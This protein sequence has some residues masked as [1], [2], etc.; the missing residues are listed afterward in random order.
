MRAVDD[1]QHLG[2]LL[3]PRG[4]APVVLAGA[5]DVVAGGRAALGPALDLTRLPQ[6]DADLRHHEADR[7]VGAHD[8]RDQRIVPAVL[9]G[10]HVALG[11]EVPGRELGGPRG[12]VR[13]HRDHREVEVL[14]QP[15][16][17]VEVHRL[18]ARRERVV[19]PRHRD[20][21]RVDGVDLLGPRVDE[22]QVVAGPR[23][24][25]ADVA[26]HRARPD[27]EDLLHDGVTSAKESGG[28][29]GPAR[30]REPRK[31]TARRAGISSALTAS[32]S[33]ARRR[34]S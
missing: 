20:A 14:G 32:R 2:Q 13:L 25:R 21:A 23:Q 34:T 33:P 9:R 29:V 1:R 16:R 31:Y 4:D 11:A 5:E 24:E 26:A 15:R 10:D 8:R 19:R 12:V 7:A 18:R 6:R 28:P 17:L 22:G 30:G 27:E 3:H